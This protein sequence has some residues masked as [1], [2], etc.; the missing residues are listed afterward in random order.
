MIAT[1]VPG[2][3]IFKRALTSGVYADE[4]VNIYIGNEQVSVKDIVNTTSKNITPIN[5][6]KINETFQGK[7][8]SEKDK[9]L[10]ENYVKDFINKVQNSKHLRNNQ[11]NSSKDFPIDLFAIISTINIY[12]VFTVNSLKC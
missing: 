3:V 4:H 7:N 6:E 12:R 11:E 9:D 8:V 2:Y 1:V 5:D 10:Y